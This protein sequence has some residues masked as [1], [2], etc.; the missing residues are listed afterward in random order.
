MAAERLTLK[1][2]ASLFASWAM[3]SGASAQGVQGAMFDPAPVDIRQSVPNAT[4]PITPKDLLT[5]REPKGLSLSPDAKRVAFVVGQAVYET[6]GYRS[7]LFIV[8]TAGDQR[9][10]SLGSAGM[11]HWDDINQWI[12]EAPQWSSDSKTIWYR[13][14]MRSGG[15]FQVWSWNVASMRRQQVTHVPGDV[16]NYRYL[17]NK[18]I[19]FLSIA[20]PIQKAHS[21]GGFESGIRFTGQIRPYQTIS[22]LD[23]LKAAEESKHES[24]IHDLRTGK[25]RPA[26]TKEM[27]EWGQEETGSDE[28]NEA[29]RKVLTQYHVVKRS[30]SPDGDH[31]A[32]IHVVDDPAKSATWSRRL[33]LYSKSTQG[34][35]ALTP[36]AYFVDQVWWNADGTLF[37]TERDGHG[38]SPE[39]WKLAPGSTNA[40]AVFKAKRAEYVSSF[41]S[42]QTGRFMSCVIEDNVSPP[43]I[44]VLDTAN[45]VIRILADL[46]PGFG[47]LRLSPVERIEGTNRFGESW[48]AY[49][50]KPSDYKIGTRYP[51]I[52]T[53]YRSGD[54]FLRGGSGDEN[55]IQIY[56][57]NGFAV[58]CFDV[59]WNRN[60]PV[61]DFEKK[62]QDWA[63]PTASMEAAVEQLNAQEIIDPKRVGIAGFSHGEEIAGYAVTHTHLFRAAI[64]AAFYDPCFY[65]LGGA[66]WWSVFEK[67]GLGGWPEGQAKANWQQVAMSRNAERIQTPI[68]ENASDTEYLIYLPVYRS[69]LDL[70]KPVELYLYPKELHVRNQPKHRY[71]IYERNLDWFLFWLK[72]VERP[73]REKEDQYRHWREMRRQDLA[74]HELGGSGSRATPDAGYLALEWLWD[75]FLDQNPGAATKEGNPRRLDAGALGNG[76]NPHRKLST[77]VGS[78]D[79]DWKDPHPR[80]T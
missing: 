76:L 57:A 25:E 78:S 27:R 43:R 24:W 1:F 72:D 53:T 74:S 56:A 15:H 39:L 9:I 22:V 14:C 55:P 66:D 77:P 3:A 17:S 8:S 13:A 44:A 16:E 49:L 42:D 47:S 28:A 30:S 4:R 58:L 46:N 19:L 73:S 6:N 54:Y 61:G 60:I 59:G 29:E 41:T 62:L 70:G 34:W 37:F 64:G 38:H 26:T 75:L 65:Y 5:L 23:Q 80:W 20:R 33:L 67:W 71:E 48:F 52:I 2:A 36:D 35:I 68:L 63:S 18:R 11:P 40:K 21:S 7:G 45:G 10:H 79:A 69:L 12:A 32:F 31:I 50:V 51:L